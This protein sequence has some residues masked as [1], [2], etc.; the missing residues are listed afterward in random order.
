MFTVMSTSQP[1]LLSPPAKL[2]DLDIPE[3]VVLDLVLVRTFVQERTSTRKLAEDLALSPG[4]VLAVFE[5]LRNRRFLDVHGLVGDDYTFSL[6]TDGRAHATHRLERC[7]YAGAAPVSLT[8]YTQVVALQQPELHVNRALVK[9]AFSDLV[10]NNAMLDQIG[11][12]FV[13]QRSIFLYGPTGT[14]KTSLAE[15]LVRMYADGIVV[16]HAVEVDGQIVSVFDPTVHR[17]L[18][19]QPAGL[20]RRWVACE[21]PLVITGGELEMDMLQMRRDPHTGVY[22]APL[23]MRANN[24]ILMID[25][26]GRQMIPPE[27]LLNRW[28]VPLDRRIDYLS[29]DYGAKFTIPFEVLVVFSTNLD[30]KQLGDDAFFRRIQNKVYVGPVTPEEFDQIALRSADEYHVELSFGALEQLREVCVQ[31]S[32]TTLRACYP[33][34]VFR[35]ARVICDYDGLPATLTRSVML[36]AA[37][38]YFTIGETDNFTATSATLN[39]AAAGRPLLSETPA[40]YDRQ[41]VLIDFGSERT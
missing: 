6:T 15:R 9:K 31:L 24:G 29:L 36:R 2:A 18:D 33:R 13:G 1:A 38:L 4:I 27:A 39:A 20:D 22:A 19:P 8:H 37:Q 40:E 12:A 30:P 10:V 17:P 28:I 26:F 5:E 16:P 35:L 3:Q 14:G 23:Q 25:D 7:T 32:G 41:P 21:R 34:D 11:P